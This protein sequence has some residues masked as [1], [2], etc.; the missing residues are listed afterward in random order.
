MFIFSLGQ[1]INM[2]LTKKEVH[3]RKVMILG[4]LDSKTIKSTREIADLLDLDWHS[5]YPFLRELVED[6][7]VEMLVAKN[8]KFWRRII[9]RKK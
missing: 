5:V 8:G 7:R 9:R 2:V 6:G 1:I 4:V 3:E